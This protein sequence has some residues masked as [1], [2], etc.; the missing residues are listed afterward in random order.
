MGESCH[1]A[2]ASPSRFHCLYCRLQPV[3]PAESSDR[4][5]WIEWFLVGSSIFP[6]VFI[7]GRH[8]DAVVDEQR[9]H[10]FYPKG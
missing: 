4:T 6:F 10:S 7:S 1:E 3:A 5:G 2:S 8:S 9:T